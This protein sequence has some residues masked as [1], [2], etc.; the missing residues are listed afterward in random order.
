MKSNEQ[1]KAIWEKEEQAP[2]CG[3]DFSH[4]AGRLEEEPL[5]WDYRQLVLSFL[6]PSLRLLDM[7]T[8]AGEFLLTLGHP[9]TLTSVTEGYPPNLALCRER[10]LPLGIEVS[11]VFESGPLP[12]EDGRFDLVLN[13]HESFDPAEARRVLKPGGL[14]LTQQVGGRNNR[15]LSRLLIPDFISPFPHHDLTHCCKALEQAGFSVFRGEEYFPRS[16]FRDVGALVYFA[17]ALPW[18]FP[19]FSVDRCFDRLLEAQAQ[20][21]REGYLPGTEHR[22][23]L[24]ARSPVPPI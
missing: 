14:F 16:R 8:G 20:L 11:L 24:A 21:E 19:G 1:Y 17:K 9:Y 13:R 6:A 18:E 22:F 12:F 23:L 3:W 4:L 15:D 10:L 5:P 7:G 2:F